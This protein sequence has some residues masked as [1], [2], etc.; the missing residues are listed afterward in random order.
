NPM[1]SIE[2]W[3]VYSGPVGTVQTGFGAALATVEAVWP[4]HHYI[5]APS[6][7]G[8]LAPHPPPYDHEVSEGMT[9]VGFE[10][11]GTFAQA[12][13]Q[14]QMGLL[15]SAV[16]VPAPAAPVGRTPDGDGLPMIPDE[17]Q[18]EVDG[19]L[20]VNGAIVDPALGDGPYP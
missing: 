12:A 7:I 18:I 11:C 6:L 9:R 19:N 17:A 20:Y 16:I 5:P 15:F 8:P 2:D 1:W 3:Q 4:G 13:W 10:S 14:G